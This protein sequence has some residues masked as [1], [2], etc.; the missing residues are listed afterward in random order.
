MRPWLQLKKEYGFNSSVNLPSTKVTS[1]CSPIIHETVACHFCQGLVPNFFFHSVRSQTSCRFDL[2]LSY[3]DWAFF[4]VFAL[5]AFNIWDRVLLHTWGWS[6]THGPSISA[7]G[8]TDISGIRHDS[9]LMLLFWKLLRSSTHFSV[10]LLLPSLLICK[11]S[12]RTKEITQYV[13]QV[14]FFTLFQ[15][16]L[17]CHAICSTNS[18]LLSWYLLNLCLYPSLLAP[19]PNYWLSLPV[20]S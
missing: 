5:Y 13:L 1:T 12:L 8:V 2:H 11:D 20:W 3:W 9:Q 17:W 7:P 14:L 6:C 16:T 15:G 18:C 10:R 4:I 19:K